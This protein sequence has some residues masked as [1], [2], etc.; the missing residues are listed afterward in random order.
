MIR[1]SLLHSKER[2]PQF[3]PNQSIKYEDMIEGNRLLTE[4]LC[5][6][7]APHVVGLTIRGRSTYVILHDWSDGTIH[8]H[9]WSF[10]GLGEIEQSVEGYIGGIEEK[11]RMMSQLPFND[12]ELRLVNDGYDDAVIGLLRDI[13]A[14]YG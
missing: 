12:H 8:G 10:G 13:Y 4:I 9:C 7:T 11:F 5:E 2:L 6:D 3:L 14:N 1:N